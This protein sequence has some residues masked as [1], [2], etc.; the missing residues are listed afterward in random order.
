MDIDEL[1]KQPHLSHSGISDYIECGLLYKFA[2]IDKIK[3]PFR[4]DALELGSTIHK[5]LADFYQAK[6]IGEILP[7]DELQQLFETYWKKTAE[8]KGDIKY[9]AGKDYK[10]LLQ[11]GKHLLKAYYDRLPEEDYRVLAI[12]EPFQFTIEGIAVPII[13]IFDL[14]EEDES[15]AVIITDWKTSSKAYSLADVDKSLQLTLYHLAVQMNGY[16]DREILLRFDCLIKTKTPTFDQYYTVRTEKDS[17]RALKK[18][19]RVWEGI[20]KGI[21]IPNDQS[22]KCKYCTYKSSCE[23]WFEGGQNDAS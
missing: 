5:V 15:G 11:E 18:I 16:S 9:K 2:R 10:S 3:R 4:S 22:W 7:L 21:F 17:R 23:E 6:M 13:G 19:Q 20:T 8:N 14:V 12:E 1:R